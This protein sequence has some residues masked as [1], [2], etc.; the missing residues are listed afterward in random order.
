MGRLF[1]S[2]ALTRSFRH[3]DGVKLAGIIYVHR[4]S[5]DKFGGLAAKNFR[6]FRE[7]CGEEAMKNVI[8]MTNMW[9][10][11]TPEKGAARE[12]QLKAKYFKEA[13]GKGAK[14]YRHENTPESA[15][16]ILR[17]ILHN[18]PVVLKIQREMV[19][20]GKEIGQTGAGAELNRDISQLVGTH[21]EEIKGLEE[22]MRKVMKEKD[23]ESRREFE[24]EMRKSRQ[25]IAKLQEEWKNS[26]R[27]TMA[28]LRK[29]PN[30]IHIPW[31]TGLGMFASAVGYLLLGAA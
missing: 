5:D 21:E 14:M 28:D 2:T 25:E 7:L 12:Q 11:V 13:I 30:S 6:M 29:S 27:K 4:I 8:L 20:E 1:S 18:E 22:G 3:S 19:D 31:R 26:M 9:G 16:E 17:K 10:R 24:E 23:E 15:Q